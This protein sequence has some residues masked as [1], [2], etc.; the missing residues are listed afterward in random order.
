MGVQVPMTLNMLPYLEQSS[1]DG[2][3][4]ISLQA[5][6]TST[7]FDYEGSTNHDVSM[8]VLDLGG[9]LRTRNLRDRTDLIAFHMQ[10]RY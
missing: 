5:A 1:N 4:N 10:A 9:Q 7:R 8:S 3:T 2:G 6:K